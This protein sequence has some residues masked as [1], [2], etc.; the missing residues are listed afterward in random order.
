MRLIYKSC[1]M[2]FLNGIKLEKY[3]GMAIGELELNT[4]ILWEKKGKAST[5]WRKHNTIT[6]R[7]MKEEKSNKY[8]FECPFP[9]RKMF[10]S[11][12]EI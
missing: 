2:T 1:Y 4:T 10:N 8:D 5:T 3:L 7:M 12:I 11:I 9:K 6:R